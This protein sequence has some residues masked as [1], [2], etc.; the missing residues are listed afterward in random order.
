MIK[1]STS[2][3]KFSQTLVYLGAFVALG[4]ANAS[5]GATLPG[6][7]SNTQTAL[8]DMGFLFTAR[9]LGYLAGSLTGGRLYDYLPGHRLM[10]GMIVSLAIAMMLVPLV[11]LFWLLIIVMLFM[12]LSES[13]LDIGGNTLLVWLHGKDVGPFMNSLHFAFG[14]GA[15]LSPIIIAQAV[16]WGGNLV[17]AYGGLALLI[18]LSGL[19]L[20]TMPTPISQEVADDSTKAEIN[21]QLTSLIAL[22]F[23]VYVGIEV[24]I[25]GWILTYVTQLNLTSELMASYLTAGFWGAL[26]L[27][28]LVSIPLAT[29]LR[30]RYILILSLSGTLLMIGIMLLQPETISLIWL[31]TL[32]SGF[33]MAAIFPTTLS[34]AE[35]HMVITGQVTGL[36]FVGASLG[37][38]ILP[39]LVGQLFVIIAPIALFITVFVNV[40]VGLVILALILNRST[41]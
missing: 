41:N 6:L 26:T 38:M 30:P 25:G 9:S 14:L 2:Q 27:G 39:W 28:R 19:R 33:C 29:R 36:F 17:W 12:G 10:F 4:L 3:T 1:S 7:A 15:F 34:L 20:L 18:L 13:I 21:Y 5:L 23:F 16:L 8:Q 24:S 40:L 35:R 11:S 32:G 31:G 37:G 22:F